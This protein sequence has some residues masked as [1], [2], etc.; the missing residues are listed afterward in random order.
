MAEVQNYDVYYNGQDVRRTAHIYELIDNQPAAQTALCGAAR[1]AHQRPSQQATRSPN[2]VCQ[3]CERI[4][5]ERGG[6][7]LSP[8]R[9]P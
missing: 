9:R 2:P 7:P 1:P 6:Q 4:L 8:P 5:T 3:T